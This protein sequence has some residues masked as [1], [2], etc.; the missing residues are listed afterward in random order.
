M[1][2][3][4]GDD[5]GDNGSTFGLPPFRLGIFSK[6]YRVSYRE[7]ETNIDDPPSCVF[8]EESFLVGDVLP[9]Q[10]S[11]HGESYGGIPNARMR[12][13]FYAFE[14]YRVFRKSMLKLEGSSDEIAR[15]T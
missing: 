12:K 2:Y 6:D 5:A 10:C 7:M 13:F 9:P 15:A 3:K 14:L 11:F 8:G 4:A 1:E